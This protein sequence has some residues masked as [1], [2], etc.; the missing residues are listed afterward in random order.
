[1]ELHNPAVLGFVKAIHS[2]PEA[3]VASVCTGAFILA[4]A[5]LLSGKAATTHWMDLD[6][7]AREYPQ[8]AVR[9]GAKFV[10]EGRVLTAG[11]ISAG[12][13]LALHLVARW[14]G[15]DVAVETARRMEY[16]ITL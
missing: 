14:A 3:T 16:D 6:R 12:I 10:D 7:L 15:R 8:V 2:Q 13:H 11:G 1:M 9:R 4:E 5:G